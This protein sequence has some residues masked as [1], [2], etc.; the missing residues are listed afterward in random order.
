[1]GLGALAALGGGA[2][3]D[4]RGRLR[5]YRDDWAEGLRQRLRCGGPLEL[6]KD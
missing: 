1:M 2:R 3:A 5:H 6:Q 4:V